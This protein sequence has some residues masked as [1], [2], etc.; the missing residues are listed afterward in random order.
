MFSDIRFAFRSLVRSPG[1][2]LA[3]LLTLAIG[4]GANAAVLAVVNAVLLRPLPYPAADRLVALTEVGRLQSVLAEGV[5]VVSLPN[6]E[7]WQ[8]RNR[9]FD[10]I[11]G[12][13]YGLFSLT[14]AGDPE[15]LLG[16]GVSSDFFDATDTPPRLGRSFRPE[17]DGGS[18]PLHVIIS[19]RLWRERL[20]AAPDA[21]GRS[22]QINGRPYTVIGVMGPGY[23]FPATIPSGVTVDVRSVELWVPLRTQDPTNVARGNRNYMALGRLRAGVSPRTAQDDL[24][25]IARELSA[26]YPAE[27]AGQ[28]IGLSLLKDRWVGH[29]R[30]ALLVL[31]AAIGCVLLVACV[32]VANLILARGRSRLRELS[33]RAALGASPQRLIRQLAVENL[34][35]AGMGG[36][37]GLFVAWAGLQG[38]LWLRPENLPRVEQIGLDGWSLLTTAGLTL[39]TALLVGLVPALRL[40]RSQSLGIDSARGVSGTR[41]ATRTRQLLTVSQ[42]AVSLMLLVGAGLLLKSFIRLTRAELGFEPEG[43]MTV[44]LILPLSQYQ[45]ADWAPFFARV[46][47]RLEGDPAIDMA[48]STNVLPL[49]G[50][51]ESGSF[52]IEGR[53]PFPE[54]EAP[55]VNLRYVSP[56]YL[57]IMG[58]RVLEGRPFAAS[59]D[60]T[61][62]NV[63]IVS[64]AVARTYL[65]GRAV[66]EAI[67]FGGGAP[68]QIVGVVNDVHDNGPARD[69]PLTVYL[70][71]AQSGS[72]VGFFTVKSRLPAADAAERIKEAVLSVDNRQPLINVRPMSSYVDSVLSQRRFTAA[73]MAVFAAIA[74]GLAVVGLYG[75]IAYMVSQ[76]TR[77]IGI[78]MALGATSGSVAGGVVGQGVRL[79]LAG[80]GVG[81]ILAAGLSRLLGQLLFGV[82][83]LDPVVYG[84][85]ALLL[86][87]V[88]AS[89]SF[90]P[91]RRAAA[92]D[93]VSALKSD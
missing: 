32:N 62:G 3:A 91:A 2:T 21:V 40:A 75:V 53:D 83:G 61:S 20:N 27:N 84:G 17:D 34:V 18:P 28:G 88:A 12:Y 79:A 54:G 36:V 76:R 58:I 38:L 65:S 51:G 85:V 31:L 52:Q 69:A 16:A 82:S 60:T 73:L 89:A 33:V 59:D 23:E 50:F 19:D 1:F 7:D 37:A 43:V 8:R 14:Q 5:D 15:A 93:P 4:I 55:E 24:D 56:R 47:D 48:G 35:L 46:I 29:A 71:L 44:G 25:R 13:Q 49:T 6:L 57:Q 64:Q 74:L 11:V 70:P 68:R 87:A 81:L 10:H 78:R 63:V 77:E 41:G 39:L 66:G 22:L 67:R 80:V 9:T 42:V 30:P 72:P 90:L 92:V 86:V 45:P 26:E